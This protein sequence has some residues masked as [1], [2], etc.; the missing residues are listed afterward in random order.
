MSRVTPAKGTAF[1][2]RE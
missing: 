1:E 2:I